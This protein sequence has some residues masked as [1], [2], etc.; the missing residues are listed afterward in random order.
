MLALPSMTKR[1][2]RYERHKAAIE[3][4]G[5]DDDDDEEG[6]SL[7][8][9]DDDESDEGEGEVFD[10]ESEAEL[11]DYGNT[12]SE[13]AVDSGIGGGGQIKKHSN[14]KNKKHRRRRRRALSS[15]ADSLAACAITASTAVNE[16]TATTSQALCLSSF[17]PII[18]TATATVQTRRS[19]NISIQKTFLQTFLKNE[20]ISESQTSQQ[21]K[22][23]ITIPIITSS[24]ISQPSET[25]IVSSNL[26]EN[27]EKLKNQNQQFLRSTSDPP[28]LDS[29]SPLMLRRF[30]LD[31]KCDTEL[32]LLDVKK[33]NNKKLNYHVSL[34]NNKKSMV[35][36]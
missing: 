16:K 14:K 36:R 21:E 33:L 11:L 22:N 24:T 6:V 15:G 5:E 25:K 30:M 8:E 7:D 18:G 23:V 12:E 10:D 29:N 28:I 31:S 35:V 27:F 1:I 4:A 19:S 32:E 13:S 17:L 20:T 2:Q 26:K 9:E 34:I 3:D